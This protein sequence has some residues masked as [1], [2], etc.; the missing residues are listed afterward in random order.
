MSIPL[1]GTCFLSHFKYL[2]NDSYF[3]TDFQAQALGDRNCTKQPFIHSL[4][5]YFPQ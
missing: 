5:L 4:A 3:H 2:N 1:L